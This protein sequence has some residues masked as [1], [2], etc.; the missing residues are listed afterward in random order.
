M[1]ES[2]EKARPDLNAPAGR[3]VRVEEVADRLFRRGFAAAIAAFAAG[4]AVASLVQRI[5]DPGLAPR[6]IRLDTQ[7]V[8]RAS[9]G[10][11]NL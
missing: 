11:R 5:R 7:L 1:G 2:P 10:P 6:A 8:V 9:S 3:Q 4:A